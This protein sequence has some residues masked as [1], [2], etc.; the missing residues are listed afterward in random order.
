MFCVYREKWES[1]IYRAS[2]RARAVRE[3]FEETA[4]SLSLSLSS[5]GLKKLGLRELK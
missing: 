5:R 4:L 3:A 2:S 1:E